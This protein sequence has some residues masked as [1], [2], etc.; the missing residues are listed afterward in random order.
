MRKILKKSFVFAIVAAVA[1]TACKK[2]VT[3]KPKGQ[4]RLDYT[5]AKYSSFSNISP[6]CSFTFDLNEN[7]K[8]KMKQ[9]CSME[10]VYPS[11]KATIYLNY[12]PV[13]GNVNQLLQDAQKL[14]YEHVVKADDI[15]EQPFL[16]PASKVYGMFYQVGGN[17][18]TN[19]QFYVTDSVKHFVVGSMYF[20]A[21]P[22]Y[23]SV[24]P[25]AAYIKNDMRKIMETIKWK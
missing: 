8:V 20:Y 10:I 24:L 16:N 21:K 23:D 22:N 1:L 2:E 7:S 13:R 18:A 3:P 19:A 4:L 5:S 11:M 14:T 12:K 6:N 25:A 9:D 15:A 17:A